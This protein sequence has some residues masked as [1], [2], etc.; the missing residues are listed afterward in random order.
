V[1]A[2]VSASLEADANDEKSGQS[3]LRLGDVSFVWDDRRLRTGEGDLLAA[4]RA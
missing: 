3:A 2:F 1:A 4:R